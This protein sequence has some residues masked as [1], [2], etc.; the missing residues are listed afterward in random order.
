MALSLEQEP[1]V[2]NLLREKLVGLEIHLQK[3]HQSQ[4]RGRAL[5]KEQDPPAKIDQHLL[6]LQ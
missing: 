6:I 1:Q 3:D 4:S 5:S 2:L